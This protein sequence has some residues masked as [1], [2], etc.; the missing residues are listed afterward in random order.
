[1]GQARPPKKPTGHVLHD[2][3]TPR[4]ARLLAAKPVPAKKQRPRKAPRRG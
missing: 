1:M 3:L 2:A 4:E